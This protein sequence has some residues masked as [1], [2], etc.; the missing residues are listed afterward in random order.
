MNQLV[1]YCFFEKPQENIEKLSKFFLIG[2]VFFM[3]IS[4]AATNIFMFL[5]LVTW[6]LA[7]GFMAR[8]EVLRRNS[9]VHATLLIFFLVVVGSFYSSGSREDVIYQLYKYGKILFILP[10]IT[11]VQDEKWREA[12]INVF[13]MAMLITLILS[14]VSA[15]W[16]LPFVKGTA[17]GGTGNHFVFRDHIAQN[18]MMSFFVLIML[19]K[20]LVST[21][22]KMKFVFISLGLVAIFDILFLVLGRTGYVS[23]ALNLVVFL[24][25]L[26]TW[27]ERI[28]AY[29]VLAVILVLTLLY[30]SG[31][32]SRIIIA[33]NEYKNHHANDLSSVGQ[34]IEFLE[35]SM[36]LIKERPWAGF[37]TGS[38]RKELC[39][40]A[41]TTEWCN[42]GQIH[43][44][45]Q[46]MAIGIQLGIL[47]IAA[48]LIFMGA[49]VSQARMQ[50]GE[51]KLLGVGLVATLLADSLFH[52]PL[53]LIAE[54]AIFM[55]LFPIL[56]AK[57]SP[58]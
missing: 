33:V 3:P 51:F 39:R 20:G 41:D 26:K 40:V 56:L 1:D 11:L 7:G 35:K 2:A 18:L 8:W 28:W 19:A 25:F 45:N 48:Y 27:R 36:E 10:A 16:P 5:T 44:H 46:F 55:L 57:A 22:R 58:D 4:T 13:C 50:R 47:G 53:T 30:S 37:G 17:G 29:S 12:G 24:F 15:I 14:V 31:F 43:P 32:N 9:F 6:L 34:R 42:A 21:N 23:L 49:A 52:A 38:Q 54:A